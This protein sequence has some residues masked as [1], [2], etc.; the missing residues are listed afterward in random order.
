MTITQRVTEAVRLFPGYSAGYYCAAAN[1]TRE[2]FRTVAR[3]HLRKNV[4]PSLWVSYYPK[5]ADR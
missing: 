5:G 2:Q 4:E 1:V 3:R